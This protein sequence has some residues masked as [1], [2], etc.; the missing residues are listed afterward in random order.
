MSAH[1]ITFPDPSRV[2]GATISTLI[3]TDSD[4][5]SWKTTSGYRNYILFIDT[6]CDSII[7]SFE[8]DPS[9]EIPAS[10][11]KVVDLL[12][13]LDAWIDDIPPEP[14]PQRFGNRAF[15]TWGARLEQVLLDVHDV[16][17]P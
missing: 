6:L 1:A 3:K 9:T 13:Q 16:A 2:E 12:A 7:Q 10:I 15:R 17:C 4:V 11:Q 14:A 5:L 8:L